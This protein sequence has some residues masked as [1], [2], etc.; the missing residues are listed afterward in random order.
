MQQRIAHLN[1]R[2]NLEGRLKLKLSSI[3]TIST[4]ATRKLEFYLLKIFVPLS[5][6]SHISS[7]IGQ[8]VYEQSIMTQNK[9]MW[10]PTMIE[11]RKTPIFEE[12]SRSKIGGYNI[13]VTTLSTLPLTTKNYLVSVQMS[14]L[15]F[16]LSINQNV[17]FF[18]FIGYVL[19]IYSSTG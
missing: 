5:F 8:T 7:P 1:T 15:P 14:V 6:Y 2:L 16:P 18:L 4:L 13:K 11:I 19:H 12:T 10:C 17:G 3:A 9:K